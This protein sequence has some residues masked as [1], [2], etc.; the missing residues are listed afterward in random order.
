MNGHTVASDTLPDGSGRGG[1]ATAVCQ[2]PGCIWATTIRW[3]GPDTVY[4]PNAL[5][6]VHGRATFHEGWQRPPDQFDWFK[7]PGWMTRE[8]GR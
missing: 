4:E 8:P 3:E 6:V 5:A 1:V 2:T 7:R